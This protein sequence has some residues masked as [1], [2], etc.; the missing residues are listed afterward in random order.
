MVSDTLLGALITGGI[1]LFLAI[2]WRGFA[3]PTLDDVERNTNF[4]E[5]FTGEA[6]EGGD[7]QLTRL[8]K[9]FEA[10]HRELADVNAEQARQREERA[11]EHEQVLGKVHAIQR[12]LGAIAQ[13]INDAPAIETTVDLPQDNH[14]MVPDGSGRAGEHDRDDVDDAE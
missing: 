11:E 14:H 8:D 7:G 13:A 1:T 10:V 5:W 3:K 4:R 6:V 2:G 9:E 12:S